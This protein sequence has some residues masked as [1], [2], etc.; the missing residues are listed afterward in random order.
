LPLPGTIKD[1]AGYDKE[2]LPPRV[3]KTPVDEECDNEE[4]TVGIAGKDHLIS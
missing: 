3:G 2:Y 1:I 4:K